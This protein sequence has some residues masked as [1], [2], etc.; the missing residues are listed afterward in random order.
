MSMELKQMEL[1]GS[2]YAL[3]ENENSISSESDTRNEPDPQRKKL[4]LTHSNR[5]LYQV[6]LA[7]LMQD[8]NAYTL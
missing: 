1:Q 6:G 3:P 5:G 8:F 7:D 4:M 2:D